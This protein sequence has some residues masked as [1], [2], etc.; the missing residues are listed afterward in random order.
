[1]TLSADQS[2]EYTVYRRCRLLEAARVGAFRRTAV[3]KGETTTGK[4]LSKMP[5]APVVVVRATIQGRA[6]AQVPTWAVE[7]LD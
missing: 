6:E 5:Y 1:M 7:W 4:L 2:A 3:R